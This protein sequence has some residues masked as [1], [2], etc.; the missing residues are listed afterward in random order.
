MTTLNAA[1]SR[2]KELSTMVLDWIVDMMFPDTASGYMILDIDDSR[3]RQ[4]ERT[5]NRE[6][7]NQKDLNWRANG[8]AMV[9]TGYSFWVGNTVLVADRAV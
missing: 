4:A 8:K 6:W 5:K 7:A 3:F 1:T 9:R 2:R